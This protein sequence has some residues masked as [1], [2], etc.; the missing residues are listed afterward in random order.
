M[1][2]SLVGLK[3]ASATQ[4]PPCRA[5]TV[6]FREK[7]RSDS[8][9][10]VGSHAAAAGGHGGGLLGLQ[11]LAAFHAGQGVHRLRLGQTNAHRRFS[12][13]SGSGEL[14]TAGQR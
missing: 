1:H 4:R 13:A 3:S 12:R 6:P 5:G 11:N 9:G 7:A 2:E 8:G 10:V 14:Q